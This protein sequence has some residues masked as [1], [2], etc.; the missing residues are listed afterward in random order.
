MIVE[1][2][3]QGESYRIENVAQVISHGNE[4][5]EIHGSNGRNTTTCF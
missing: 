5:V 3:E 4:F 2:K 1:Y